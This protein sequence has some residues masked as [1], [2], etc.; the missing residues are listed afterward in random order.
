MNLEILL[1]NTLTISAVKVQTVISQFMIDKPYTSIFCFT[2]I[3][4]DSLNFNPIGL[5]IFSKHR[6]KKDKK[7][8]GLMIGYLDDKK[9]KL[10]EIKIDHSDILALEGTMRGSK[11]RIILTYMDSSKNKSGID[12]ERNRKI[13][14]IIEKLFEVEPDV[15]LLCLGDFNGRLKR[16]EPHI[17][18]DSN[19]KMI[20][21]WSIKYNLHHLNQ[22]ENC[23]GTYT[24]HSNKGRSAIDHMLANDR[25]YEEFRGMQIDE[26]KELLN[27]S[28]HC[29]VRAWF[30]MGPKLRTNWKIPGTKEIQ[31]IKMKN[32]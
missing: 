17:D 21:E 19:G 25:M 4:V 29:L 24:F 26:E 1:L 23:V 6:K 27:I 20:E 3:K 12:F 14:R 2:E 8:G 30:Q 32:H 13:Q 18:T 9:T 15:A 22:S 10:E 11:I 16:L 5:K 31:W 7:G 28:D